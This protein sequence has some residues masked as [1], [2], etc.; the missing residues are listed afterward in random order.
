MVK[1]EFFWSFSSI[2][3]KPLSLDQYQVKDIKVLRN[4]VNHFK[5]ILLSKNFNVKFSHKTSKMLTFD[6]KYFFKVTI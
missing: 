4:L 3:R 5:I 2:Q 1:I 6:G